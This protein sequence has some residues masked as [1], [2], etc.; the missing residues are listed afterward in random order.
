VQP[1]TVAPHTA[2]DD[3]RDT[4]DVA[5]HAERILV[6]NGASTARRGDDPARGGRDGR[7][8]DGG[9]R[10]PAGIFVSAGARVDHHSRVC[11]LTTGSV[12]LSKIAAVMDVSRAA[13]AGLLDRGGVRPALEQVAG[14]ARLYGKALTVVCVA[15]G[16]AC[17]AVLGGGGRWPRRW[18][19]GQSPGV[20]G[21]R[22]SRRRCGP[23]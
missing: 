17:F 23:G 7:R 9:V 12:E 11:R 3:L 21:W 4:L 5:L 8:V 16:C 10:H 2:P 15:L 1:N 6:E 20:P 14:Q 18:C 22:C 13:A 19:W